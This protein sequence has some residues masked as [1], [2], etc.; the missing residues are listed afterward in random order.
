MVKYIVRSSNTIQIDEYCDLKKIVI[1][2][3]S[4]AHQTIT[5]ENN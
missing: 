4:L 3:P 5:E 2:K 1:K